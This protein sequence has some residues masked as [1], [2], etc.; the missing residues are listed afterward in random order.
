MSFSFSHFRDL[1]LRKN[2]YQQVA[3]DSA[4]LMARASYEFRTSLNGIVGYAEFLENS[5]TAPMMNFTGKIIRE[6][7]SNLTRSCNSYFDLQYLQK[8][9]V[10]F[11]STQLNLQAVLLDVVNLHQ[12]YALER[13]ISIQLTY[14]QDAQSKSVC[15]DVSRIRQILDSLIFNTLKIAETWDVIRI[16]LSWCADTDK[17]LLAIELR[18][19][20]RDLSKLKLLE[21]FWNTEGYQFQLLEGPG[22]EMAL[23]KS[24]IRLGGISARYDVS[25]ESAG[26][27]QLLMPAS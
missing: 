19:T 3:P 6:S 9:Q 11:S 16:N 7:S 12:P 24:L 5:T 15:S 26:T 25:Q 27:L 14:G 8:S 23:A 20:K 10:K 1:F 22:V 2:F 4:S 17:L 13:G 18:Q 21:S